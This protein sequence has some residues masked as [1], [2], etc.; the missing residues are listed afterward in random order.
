MGSSYVLSSEPSE[1]SAGSGSNLFRALFFSL[2]AKQSGNP[3]TR[4]EVKLLKGLG[5]YEPKMNIK[6]S[7]RFGSL[8]GQNHTQAT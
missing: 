1:K 4:V 7:P 3:L 5:L 2:F 6:F 8:M